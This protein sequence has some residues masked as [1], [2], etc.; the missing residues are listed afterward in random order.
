M[1]FHHILE[2]FQQIFKLYIRKSKTLVSYFIKCLRLQVQ[3][4]ET[5]HTKY[6]IMGFTCKLHYN[7]AIDSTYKPYKPSQN[8]QLQWQRTQDF[9]T[10]AP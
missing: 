3:K 7:Y 1:A 10:Y 5:N 4:A 9:E 2:N 6:F 8:E